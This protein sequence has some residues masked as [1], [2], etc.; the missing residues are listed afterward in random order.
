MSNE[1]K[2][3][4]Y[5]K[6]A[7]ADTRR[8][9]DQLREIEDAAAEPI[10][11]VGMACRFPGAVRSPEDLWDLVAAGGDAIGTFPEDRGWDLDALLNGEPGSSGTSA[12]R[13]GGFLDDAGAFDAGFFHVSPR[14]AQAMDPQQRLLLEASWEAIEHASIDASALRGSST[15]VFVGGAVQDYGSRLHEPD[16]SAEGLRLTGSLSS[17][18]SGR[19]AYF[20]GLEGPAVTVDTACSSSLVALHLAVRSLR[21]GESG[22]AIAGGVTVLATPGTF[23]EFSRQGGLAPDGRCK[24]FGAGADGTGWAEG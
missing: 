7:I 4:E 18:L 13:H 15:G 11:I 17:V 9:Q 10:A 12:T 23:V 14:E 24:A 22:L 3:R 20:L 5:L 19:I 8:A 1:A 2:L 6:Q 16:E 21:S